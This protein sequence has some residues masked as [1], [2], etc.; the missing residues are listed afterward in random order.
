MK[1]LTSYLI[2][3]LILNISTQ[4]LAHP[5]LSESY[6]T[7]SGGNIPTNG[8]L[9]I[10]TTP[11]KLVDNVD[12]SL[13]CAITVNYDKNIPRSLPVLNISGDSQ[14]YNYQ[15]TCLSQPTT[16]GNYCFSQAPNEKY[17][18]YSQAASYVTTIFPTPPDQ[19]SVCIGFH[20][21]LSDKSI[22]LTNLD[23]TDTFNIKGCIV[24]PGI[25]Y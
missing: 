15:F 1:K 2:I 14:S 25:E 21:P 11:A 17:S 16:S 23:D 6:K 10:D 12:Y 20:T 22:H 9:N 13:C 8:K 7:L 19:L 5:N 18:W 3:G 24:S 4:T